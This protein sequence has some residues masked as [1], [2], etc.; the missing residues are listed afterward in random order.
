M[1]TRRR[2]VYWLSTAAVAAPLV[3]AATVANISSAGAV[4]P[5]L[6]PAHR[7]QQHRPRR[8]GLPLRARR[9]PE[10]RPARLRQRG[11]HLH[12]RGPAD[13]SRPSPAP[14]VSIAGPGNG[15]ST[16]IQLPRDLSGRVYFS[17]GEKLKFFLTPDGLVQ[18]A[19]W[20]R[21]RPEPRH[22][23]RLERVHLQRRRP[24]AQQLAGRHVRRA[25]RGHRHRRNGADQADRRRRSP[26][27]A[28]GSSTPSGPRPAGPTPSTPASDGTVL[29]VLAPGKAADAGLFSPTY[30]DPYITSGVERVHDQ[31][32]DRGAVRQPAEHPVLRPHQRHRHDTSP[33]APASRSRRSTSPST[34]NVWGCDGALHAPNDLVVGPIARTLCAALQPRH[35]RHHRHPAELQ[36]GR[37]LPEQ[38]R[39]TSTRG[40]STRTW[41]TARRTRFAFDDVGAFES[42]VH[43]GDPRAAGIILSPF[44]A[45]GGADGSQLRAG[46]QLGQGQ[47]LV[48]PTAGSTS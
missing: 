7:H 43:D 36:P 38:S 16:T 31:D 1:R 47:R 17:F 23:V 15:G 22:P 3:V 20:A 35:A 29:R 6:L 34:A 44:G 21:R 46:Q 12:S 42:L 4:G 45:G 33:T 9:Q 40:S 26:T 39:P 24:V 32:A 18:P 2:L 10:H 8:G 37:L 28:T 27:A 30:L 41:S 13:R 14:D 19:P 5:D 48:P 11:R 25:A